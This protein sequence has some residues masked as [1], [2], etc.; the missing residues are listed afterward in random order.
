M[1]GHELL[2]PGANV[3]PRDAEELAEK[4]PLVCGAARGLMRP[5]LERALTTRGAKICVKNNGQNEYATEVPAIRECIR[6][7][8][9]E[10]AGTYER[11]RFPLDGAFFLAEWS[12]DNE[13]ANYDMGMRFLRPSAAGVEFTAIKPEHSKSKVMITAIE[14]DHL[15]FLVAI[16]GAVKSVHGG[17]LWISHNMHSSPLHETLR[18]PVL[19][20]DITVRQSAVHERYGLYGLAYDELLG[21]LTMMHNIANGRV[22]I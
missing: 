8:D 10:G 14:G 16:R 17:S 19:G 9:E 6:K 13:S 20:S 21:H 22:I 5:L 12:G 1:P 3:Y 18:H 11:L 15:P 7:R 4:L 2:F